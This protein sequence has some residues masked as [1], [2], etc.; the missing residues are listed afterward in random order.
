MVLWNY[1]KH[2]VLTPSKTGKMYSPMRFTTDPILHT[3]TWFSFLENYTVGR[4]IFL[5]YCTSYY[6][7][8]ISKCKQSFTLWKW[9]DRL[10]KG[11]Q[12]VQVRSHMCLPRFHSKFNQTNAH[13]CIHIHTHT[14]MHTHTQAHTCTK[15]TLPSKYA[16]THP[17]SQV[18]ISGDRALGAVCTDLGELAHDQP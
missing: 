3:V 5:L 13:T 9:N 8:N 10:N 6:I 16:Q 4:L 1:I 7:I 2:Q 15:I 18:L 14:Y 12:F 17:S 11:Q